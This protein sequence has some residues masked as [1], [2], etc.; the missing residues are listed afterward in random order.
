MI[1]ARNRW[2]SGEVP[3][4]DERVAYLE[5]RLEDHNHWLEGRI[6]GLDK[7]IDRLDMRMDR[8]DTR[9]DRFEGRIDALDAKISRQFMWFVGIQ[10]AMLIAILGAVL[11]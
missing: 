3:T 1:S 11:R 6:D 10:V 7:R 4:I 8:L 9:M 5:G 2:L